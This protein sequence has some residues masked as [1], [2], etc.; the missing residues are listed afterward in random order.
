MKFAP[1]LL[2]AAC[3]AALG[4]VFAWLAG[5]S[6]TIPM[7]GAWRLTAFA[8]SAVVFLAHIRYEVRRLAHEPRTAA[9]RA[10]LAVALGA[11]VLAAKAFSL[12]VAAASDRSHITAFLVWPI[13][14]GVPAFLVAWVV[15][16][17][18]SPLPGARARDPDVYL[19]IWNG[20][21]LE[22]DAPDAITFSEA[23]AKA[24]VAASPG[25]QESY[26]IEQRDRAVLLTS[27]QFARL[28]ER[29]RVAPQDTSPLMLRP[30]AE[31]QLRSRSPERP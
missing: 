10:A 22:L 12:S 5:R 30:D 7:R 3:Y 31:R 17:A 1:I 2:A 25:R 6:A 21:M 19:V 14:T 26:S 4:I 18:L 15:A 11:L 16:A 8:L 13:I 29:I 9:F 23:D 20:E 27:P 24:L 28:A